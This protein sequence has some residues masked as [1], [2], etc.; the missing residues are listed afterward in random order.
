M[1]ES[2]LIK[3]A[4]LVLPDDCYEGDIFIRD[5]RIVD[6]GPS[7]QHPAVCVIR[8]SGLT[9]LPGVIDPHVH[10]RD[11]GFPQKETL[12]TGS[13]A[14]VAGGV[15]TFFDM[16]NTKPAC[17]TADLISQKK[18]I[19][20]EHSLANYN[21]FIAATHDNLDELNRATN[22]AGIKIFVGSSTGNLLVDDQSDLE[23][24]FSQTRHR[25]AVHSED[26]TT[27]RTNQD[28]LGDRTHPRTHADIRSSEA[29]IICTKR[30]VSLA[31]RLNRQLHICHLTTKDE[32]EFLAT[33]SKSLVTT[34]VSPQH[35]FLNDSYYDSLGT[36]LQINPP[37]RDASH[38]EALFT[39]LKSG[40]IDFVATDHAPH[41]IDEKR[42][43]YPKAPSGM[44]GIQTSLSLL[45]NQVHQ[46]Q[47]TIH[48][49]WRWM[50]YK[51]AQIYGLSSKGQLR[52]N[53][54]ADLVLVDCNSTYTLRNSDMISA[55]K[56]T[57]FDGWTVTGKPL[58]TIVNGQLVYRE[59]DFFESIKGKEAIIDPL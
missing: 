35:L 38:Q 3:S 25:I 18:A 29:A 6:I 27:I 53:Y 56:W 43:P 20:A 4:R 42:Q 17:T 15:T 2:I 22:I 40:I 37:I 10:F 1:I 14:A 7:L 33:I 13:K 8:D 23:R 50:C 5:G 16:P 12:Y 11:P 59:G 21:F 24:I 34:E 32:C 36:F 55:S 48:D 54:D 49:V 47:I 57:A 51:P 58:I 28:R 41:T 39:A 19:A 44:P 52:I 9:V 31:Q 26:E 46:K 45:L 30:L